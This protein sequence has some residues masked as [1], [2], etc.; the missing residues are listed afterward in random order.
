[1]WTGVR[2]GKVNEL[3]TAV[4]EAYQVYI[5]EDAT[6]DE[7][8]GAIRTLSEKAQELWQIVSKAELNALI[9]AAEA[10][11]ADGYTEITYRA[12]QA[13]ITA[14]QSVAA[15]DNATMAEVTTA[16]TDLASAM[17]GLEQITLDTSALEHG[18]R[19]GAEQ[20]VA[21]IDDYVPS[22]VE[23]LADK[24]DAAK[25]ALDVTSQDA[26]D[27]ATKS[28]R[29]ARLNARTKADVSALEALI[30]KVNAMD[31]R[32]YTS[33]SQSAV[34]S[35]LQNAEAAVNDAEVTQEE[36]NAAMDALN[37]AI[38]GLVKAEQPAV[39]EP[40]V[41]TP[42]AG[43]TTNTKPA[44]TAAG[45]GIGALFA[46]TGRPSAGAAGFLHRRKNRK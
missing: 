8:K 43:S 10:I 1:M 42:E 24:L 4:A 40:S 29:E 32:A 36:V 26:I 23:G 18:D 31:L 27:E 15:N 45:S 22:T 14:A 44:S 38:D 33:A 16:I 7:I 34:R 9:D 3:K 21:N 19:A 39:S 2:P 11:E 5:N 37:T 30:A 41:N 35:A 20:I 25:A 12:L 17:A 46:A 6:A 28:L 13:A